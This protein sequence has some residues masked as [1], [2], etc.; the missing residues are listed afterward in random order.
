MLWCPDNEAYEHVW[1]LKR[2]FSGDVLIIIKKLPQDLV[3]P[4]RADMFRIK[5][6]QCVLFPQRVIE[7]PT[8]GEL[9]LCPKEEE[10]LENEVNEC[11]QDKT[12]E[13]LSD[14]DARFIAAE[15]EKLDH[16]D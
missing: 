13:Q 16:W 10:K 3:P 7:Y 2:S 11:L 9:G 4:P 1:E 14:P 5:P 12:P 15:I 8:I 6:H